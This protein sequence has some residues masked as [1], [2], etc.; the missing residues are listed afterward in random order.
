MKNSWLKSNIIGIIFVSIL[1]TLSHFIYEWSGSNKI[2]GFFT[3]V[4]ESTWEHMKLLFFPML[5]YCMI[6]WFS[7][8]KI[9]K[10]SYQTKNNSRK[11]YRKESGIVPGTILIPILF[12]TY[13]GILGFHLAWIDISI[14]FISVIFAFMLRCHNIPIKIY[15]RII[16]FILI[17]LLGIG[18]C[19][20]TYYPPALGIFQIP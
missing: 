16:L 15:Q 5:F 7:K 10:L 17:L 9:N 18:F 3:P 1:G 20:F 12:Y 14:F 6:T 13:S 11:Q 19:F 4:N 8:P 2:I